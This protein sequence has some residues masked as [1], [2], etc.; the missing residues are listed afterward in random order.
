M[1]HVTKRVGTAEYGSAR[2]M[3]VG[4][5]H[6]PAMGP[7]VRPQWDSGLRR[8]GSTPEPPALLRRGS[9]GDPW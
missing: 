4:C 1:C 5:A 8:A 6:T 9:T 7:V 3:A 2:L